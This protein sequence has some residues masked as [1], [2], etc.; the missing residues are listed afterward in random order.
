MSEGSLEQLRATLKLLGGVRQDYTFDSLTGASALHALVNPAVQDIERWL[1]MGV[2][3]YGPDTQVVLNLAYQRAVETHDEVRELDI[4]T[5][6]LALSL[7]T[8]EVERLS[9]LRWSLVALILA[10]ALLALGVVVLYMRQRNAKERFAVAQGR[11]TDSLESVEQAVALFDAQGA[12]VMSNQR[13]RELFALDESALGARRPTL[14]EVVM[15][16]L[17]AGQVVSV[18]DSNEALTEEYLER[19][20]RPG[21]SFEMQWHDGRHFQVCEQRTHEDG[22]IVF[23]TDITDLEGRPAPA[24]APGHP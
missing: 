14:T 11:L 2:P 6:A 22:T 21:Q 1:L 24:R 15:R 17:E 12:L 4:R 13:Y 3:G 9:R 23:L 7:L 5:E 16:A 10:F 19:R 8:A 20:E 18:D